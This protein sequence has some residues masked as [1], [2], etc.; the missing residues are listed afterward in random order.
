MLSMKMFKKMRKGGLEPPQDF[1]HYHLKVARLPIP[2]L[3]RSPTSYLKLGKTCNM[4]I[5]YGNCV[6]SGNRCAVLT[7]L[8]KKVFVM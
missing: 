4:E 2:P 1:S 7:E 6:P 3:P 8:Y 5:V